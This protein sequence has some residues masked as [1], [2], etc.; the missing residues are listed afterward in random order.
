[1]IRNNALLVM[2]RNKFGHQYYTLVGGGIDPGETPEQALH[3]EVLEEAGLRVTNLR[4]VFRDNAGPPY[5]MQY[6]YFC[7]YLSGDVALRPDSEEAQINALGQNL[8][9]P[10]WLALDRLAEVEFLSPGLQR[11]LLQA[12]QDGWP[13]QPVHVPIVVK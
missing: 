12:L 10:M 1:M 4:M 11:A 8:Y 3:R 13:K 7:D 9:T 2:H 5:G 6:V